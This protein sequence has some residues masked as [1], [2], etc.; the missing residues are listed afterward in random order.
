ME[1]DE[2]IPIHINVVSKP[3]KFSINDKKLQ[4]LAKLL[5]DGMTREEIQ[6]EMKISKSTYYKYY[7]A[8]GE[9]VDNYI[10]G[11]ANHGLVILFKESFDRVLQKRNDYDLAISIA[12]KNVEKDPTGL[13]KCLKAAV[14]Y[15]KVILEFLDHRIM[16]SNVMKILTK[17]F[18]R[19]PIPE[20]ELYKKHWKREKKS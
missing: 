19:R 17:S 2:K 15:E 9:V 8:E 13:T 5:A 18:L 6:K 10:M 14:E 11:M 4:K 3:L 20:L 16:V 1:T 12:R 7:D